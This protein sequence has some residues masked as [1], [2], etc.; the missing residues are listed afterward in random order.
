MS[1]PNL[2]NRI[3]VVMRMKIL[4]K[5]NLKATCTSFVMA[6]FPSM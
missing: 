4:V 6:N 2:R 1:S 5:I 3:K